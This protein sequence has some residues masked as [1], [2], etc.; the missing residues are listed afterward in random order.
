[1]RTLAQSHLKYFILARALTA[2]VYFQYAA[3][4]LHSAQRQFGGVA[5]VNY[6]KRLPTFK[7]E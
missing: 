2:T 3:I 4:C 5:G 1:V 7:K 6:W